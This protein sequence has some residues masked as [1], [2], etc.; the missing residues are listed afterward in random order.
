MGILNMMLGGG[1]SGSA[2]FKTASP[3]TI[4]TSE[5]TFNMGGIPS[6]YVLMLTGSATSTSYNVGRYYTYVAIISKI[7]GFEHLYALKGVSSRHVTYE[8]QGFSN[9]TESY[10]SG[11][12]S[13]TVPTEICIFAQI[14][15][16]K[17]TLYYK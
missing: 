13:I 9:V 1:G 15:G 3:A 2:A 17:Y 11:T 7:T 14:S 4:S 6:E 10:S 12:F 16:L 5:L 8:D